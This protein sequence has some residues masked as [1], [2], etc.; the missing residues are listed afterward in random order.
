[1]SEQ[2]HLRLGVRR[3]YKFACGVEKN[4]WGSMVLSSRANYLGVTC[5]NCKRTKAY[6]DAMEA[7]RR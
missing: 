5:G 2:T 6:R 4:A 1:M 3:D 7:Q